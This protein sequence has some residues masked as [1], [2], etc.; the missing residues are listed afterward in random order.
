MWTT[1]HG[2]QADKYR[3]VNA[4][5]KEWKDTA[6]RSHLILKVAECLLDVFMKLFK[7]CL[8]L[9]FSIFHWILLSTKKYIIYKMKINLVMI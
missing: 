9:C 5:Y 4:H 2:L 7:V 6:A 8:N 1:V 3:R